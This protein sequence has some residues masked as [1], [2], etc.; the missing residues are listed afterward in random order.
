V[1]KRATVLGAVILLASTL[2]FAAEEVEIR[3]KDGVD[4]SGYLTYA[5]TSH[6]Y[7]KPDSPLREGAPLDQ[8]IRNA[9]DKLIQRNGFQRVERQD[10]P[11]LMINYVGMGRDYF[12]AEGVTKEIAPGVKWIGDPNAHSMRSYREGTL[13]FEVIDTGTEEMIWSGWVTELAPTIAKLQ[14]KAE[15]ATRKVFKH[16]PSR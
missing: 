9:A 15:K 14:A 11:D 8:K 12:H 10:S 13:V 7:L 4:F 16:F 6:E 1:L 3:A 2:A 5:W